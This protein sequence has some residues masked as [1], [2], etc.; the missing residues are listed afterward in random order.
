MHGA[1]SVDLILCFA[2]PRAVTIDE[3]A[4]SAIHDEGK[5]CDNGTE[6]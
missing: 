2:D 3:F 1:C 6:P 4:V 5:P